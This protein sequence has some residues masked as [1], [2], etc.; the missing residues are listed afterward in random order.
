MCKGERNTACTLGYCSFILLHGMVG[1]GINN[2]D[3]VHA[4]FLNDLM[5]RERNTAN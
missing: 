5:K 2:L 1:G 4:V 3:K